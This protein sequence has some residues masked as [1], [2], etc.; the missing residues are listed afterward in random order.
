MSVSDSASKRAGY[1][2]QQFKNE[3]QKRFNNQVREGKS[4][5]L[6]VLTQPV[7]YLLFSFVAFSSPDF[8]TSGMSSERTQLQTESSFTPYSLALWEGARLILRIQP[9]FQSEQQT[10]PAVE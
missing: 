5:S 8:K 10:E 4:I 1:Q 9:C 7:S 3:T 2:T 6:L